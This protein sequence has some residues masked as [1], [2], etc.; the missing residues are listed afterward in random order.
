MTRRCPNL[1][2]R[3]PLR[4]RSRTFWRFA[5]A[6]EAAA[7][8]TP[9]RHA[10]EAALA[11][12]PLIHGVCCRRKAPF[13]SA[14]NSAAVPLLRDTNRHPRLAC[15]LWCGRVRMIWSLH[16]RAQQVLQPLGTLR[17]AAAS[18]QAARRAAVPGWLHPSHSRYST[19][20]PRHPQNLAPR[21]AAK[22]QIP[23]N[24]SP[25]PAAQVQILLPAAIRSR[26]PHCALLH[27]H[28]PYLSDAKR[29]CAT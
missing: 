5:H 18:P 6:A 10:S 29:T 3:C 17:A 4:A 25:C 20:E 12:M 23:Q 24:L 21:L 2:P 27:L 19:G 15:E 9:L 26:A 11:M 14:Q 22:V 28:F 16:L 7:A 1:P 8:M 13:D